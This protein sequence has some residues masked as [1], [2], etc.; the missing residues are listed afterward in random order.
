MSTVRKTRS[1]G[2]DLPQDNGADVEAHKLRFETEREKLVAKQGRNSQIF[3]KE[4]LSKIISSI[5]NYE[6]MTSPVKPLINA[7]I[8]KCCFLNFDLPICSVRYSRHYLE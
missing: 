3:T 7:V 8:M 6:K 5:E 2:F 1:R 4:R